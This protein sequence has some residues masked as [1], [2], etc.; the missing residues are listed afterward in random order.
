MGTTHQSLDKTLMDTMM[1]NEEI[2]KAL[3][4]YHKDQS[5]KNEFINHKE[6]KLIVEI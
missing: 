6:R 5:Y 1:T 4:K 3:K 2:A